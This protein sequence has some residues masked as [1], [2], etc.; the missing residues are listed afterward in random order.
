MAA[1]KKVLRP[2]RFGITHQSVAIKKAKRKSHRGKQHSVKAASFLHIAEAIENF[3]N[4]QI[5]NTLDN[6]ALLAG[7]C[8]I[9]NNEFLRVRKIL[10]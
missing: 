2:V 7:L 9:F 1:A 8:N 10:R 5:V 4:D 3:S 6:K